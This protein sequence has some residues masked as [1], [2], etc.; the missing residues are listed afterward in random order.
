MLIHNSWG[1]FEKSIK[2]KKKQKKPKQTIYLNRILNGTNLEIVFVSYR[3]GMRLLI[4]EAIISRHGSTSI[5]DG[6][7]V[8]L[9]F[10]SL[11]EKKRNCFDKEKKDWMRINDMNEKEWQKNTKRYEWDKINKYRF[12]ILLL[13][14]ENYFNYIV[15]AHFHRWKLHEYDDTKRV[16]S[17]NYISN[18]EVV[19]LLNEKRF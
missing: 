12:T 1:N 16:T 3:N 13:S 19:S 11:S 4:N 15:F 10:Y 9:H 17:S 18:E 14:I 7:R 6:M 5:I 8:C 2:K